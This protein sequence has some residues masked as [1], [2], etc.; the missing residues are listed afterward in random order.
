VITKSIDM[1]ASSKYFNASITADSRRECVRKEGKGGRKEVVNKRKK[2]EVKAK[3][4]KK[5]KRGN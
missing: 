1:F 4:L 2:K 5:R 3:R